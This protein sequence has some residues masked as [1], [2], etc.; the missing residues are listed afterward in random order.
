M[1]IGSIAQSP[2]FFLAGRSSSPSG[3]PT[4]G[5]IMR[6]FLEVVES[7]W[8]QFSCVRFGKDHEHR[9]SDCPDFQ[10]WLVSPGEWRLDRPGLRSEVG[11]HHISFQPFEKCHRIVS[12]DGIGFSLRV[13]RNQE[14]EQLRIGYS[15]LWRMTRLAER[16]QLDSVTLDCLLQDVPVARKLNPPSW[17]QKVH[18]LLHDDPASNWTIRDF[19]EFASISPSHLIHEY[20]AHYGERLFETR[21]RLRVERF[22]ATRA[23]AIELGFYDQAHLARETRRHLGVA[24]TSAVL[25]KTIGWSTGNT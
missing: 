14:T 8:A 25:Y 5:S 6:E 7:G 22:L 16:R 2:E 17:L 12:R 11:G 3:S 24:P 21:N 1:D 10:H 19:A 23:D 13:Y 4:G 20:K 18:G 9:R 15:H